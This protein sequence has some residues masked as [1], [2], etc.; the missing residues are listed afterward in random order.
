MHTREWIGPKGGQGNHCYWPKMSSQIE[1]MISRFGECLKY[2]PSK[3]KKELK[4]RPVPTQAWQKI[5][6]DLFE[7]RQKNYLIITDYYSLQPEVYELKAANSK[8]VIVLMRDIF[9]R[10]GVP[11]EL[12]SDN[13]SQ[14]KSKEFRRFAKEWDFNLTT[15]S[16]VEWISRIISENCKADDEEVFSYR[17]RHTSGAIS[18]KKHTF[19]QPS[20]AFN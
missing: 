11:S 2:K 16:S 15:I 19:S 4:P 8:Q 5:G 12:V 9:A 13:G 14:Y 6:S 17:P 18:H 20:R 1:D 3:H 7:L 10:H